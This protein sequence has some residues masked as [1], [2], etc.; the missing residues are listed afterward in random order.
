[1]V[2]HRVYNLKTP[3]LKFFSHTELLRALGKLLERQKM[4]VIEWEIVESTQ[5]VCCWL[6]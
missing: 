2:D 6:K 3:V 4:I 1:M 5:D